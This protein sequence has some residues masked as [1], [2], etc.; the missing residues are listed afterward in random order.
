MDP[1]EYKRRAMHQTAAMLRPAKW[2][3][4]E[5]QFKLDDPEE[6]P[7]IFTEIR[8]Q[9]AKHK[10]PVKF[11]P[12]TKTPSTLTDGWGQRFSVYAGHT[13]LFLRWLWRDEKHSFISPEMSIELGPVDLKLSTS[14]N[15][16]ALSH[17]RSTGRAM[18]VFW[19]AAR[20]AIAAVRCASRKKTWEDVLPSNIVR[21][22]DCHLHNLGLECMDNQRVALLKSPSQMRRFKKQR[23]KGCCGSY[24]EVLDGPD[25]KKYILG[26]NHGH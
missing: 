21:W 7:L 15:M 23:D 22:A 17:L 26:C 13:A 3:R 4:R 6:M 14:D 8:Q 24:E 10:T 5:G 16:R 20:D 19:V 18:H 12:V 2:A 1:T 25:G 9:A 11:T